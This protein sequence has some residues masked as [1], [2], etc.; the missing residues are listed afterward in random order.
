MNDNFIKQ[1][2]LQLRSFLYYHFAGE[3]NSTISAVTVHL[4]VLTKKI[5]DC[6]KLTVILTSVWLGFNR[7]FSSKSILA[8]FTNA[9][10][11]FPPKPNTYVA[12]AVP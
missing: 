10:F 7:F 6:L 2:V 3:L 9:I 4:L 5:N 1:W 8:S 12:I 11:S